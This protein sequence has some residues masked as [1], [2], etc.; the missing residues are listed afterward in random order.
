MLGPLRKVMEAPVPR[1]S[2]RRGPLANLS[3]LFVIRS[4]LG[5]GPAPLLWLGCVARGGRWGRRGGGR[6]DGEGTAFSFHWLPP[7]S[8]REQLLWGPEGAHLLLHHY[9]VSIQGQGSPQGMNQA[10]SVETSSH[11]C[12]Q[13]RYRSQTK[14]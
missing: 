9:E 6:G 14:G 7:E 1:S 13:A 10:D 8:F 3:I 4:R 2:D 12:L 5:G 11:Y